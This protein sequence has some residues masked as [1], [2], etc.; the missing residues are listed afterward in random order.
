[1][2]VPWQRRALPLF[3]LVYPYSGPERDQVSALA[4]ALA[5]LGE[6]LPGKRG[7]YVLVMDRGFPSNPLITEL[8]RLGWRFVLRVKS[9]WRMEHRVYTGQ[10]RHGF[11]R[12]LDRLTP[13]LLREVRFGS[14]RHGRGSCA[15]LV[16]F[17]GAGH[18]APWFLVTSEGSAST[19][20]AI[21][22]E[23][24]R[25][26]QEFRDLKGPL[27]LDLLANWLDRDRV[28]RFLAWVAVYEWRLAYLWRVHDLATF[29]QHIKIK[30]DLS[31]IRTVRE[32]I[33]RQTRL[34]AGPAPAYL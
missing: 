4:Q 15:H 26:E 23:R 5:W 18:L 10:M 11:L 19:A 31:W 32:W 9:N 12:Q 22:R 13:R 27:G 6:Q 2:S 34:A 21:Y 17:W 30:G 25:I 24:M 28:A 8:Q 16:Q 1:V 14:P 29:A 33:K 7:R 20:V 3:R